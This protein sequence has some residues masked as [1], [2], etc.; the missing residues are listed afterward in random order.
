MFNIWPLQQ[1]AFA[2]K[3][4]VF[5]KRLRMFPNT[6]LAPINVQRFKKFRQSGEISPNLGTLLAA[7]DDLLYRKVTDEVFFIFN[8]FLSFG[9]VQCYFEKQCFL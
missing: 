6:I 3:H 2:Q 4:K 8:L 7:L 1:T 9:V 5:A